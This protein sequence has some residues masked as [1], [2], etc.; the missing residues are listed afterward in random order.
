[1]DCL[2][3]TDGACLRLCFISPVL[4][5]PPIDIRAESLMLSVFVKKEGILNFMKK[6][7]ACLRMENRLPDVVIRRLL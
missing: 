5:R 1:V 2:N 3:R 6:V 4:G 7:F